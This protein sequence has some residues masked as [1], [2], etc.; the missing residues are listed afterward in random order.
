[1]NQNKVMHFRIDKLELMITKPHRPDCNQFGG[2]VVFCQNK[3]ILF[4]PSLEQ[5]LFPNLEIIAI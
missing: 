1:M 4:K 5:I 2:A 3:N